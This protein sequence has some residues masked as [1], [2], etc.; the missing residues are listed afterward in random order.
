MDYWGEDEQVE[1]EQASQEL[2]LVRTL[3][4]QHFP[5]M[6]YWK[7]MVRTPADPIPEVDAG[8]QQ[9]VTGGMPPKRRPYPFAG[10]TV[11]ATPPEWKCINIIYHGSFA[12]MH[13]GHI[14]CIRDAMALLEEHHL[15]I[16]SVIVGCTTA[17]QVRKKLKGETPFTEPSKRAKLIK[18]VLQ[19]E[20]MTSVIVDEEGHSSSAALAWKHCSDETRYTNVYLSGSDV[21]SRPSY[22]SLMV[23]RGGKDKVA[24][25]WL[26]KKK[27]AGVCPQTSAIGSSSTSIRERFSRGEIPE[28]YQQNAR[29]YLGELLD[30][31]AAQ[32]HQ[33][34]Q[35]STGC[36]QDPTPKA[37]PMP[38][39]RRAAEPVELRT[40]EA[41]GSTDRPPLRRRITQVINVEADVVQDRPPL[42]RRRRQQ[43]VETHQHAAE[44]HVR[45]DHTLHR[46]DYIP[47]L[48]DASFT[49]PNQRVPTV[50][51]ED[52][53]TRLSRDGCMK[54]AHPLF[55]HLG[56]FHR[57]VVVPVCSLYRVM[58]VSTSRRSN[59]N[60]IRVE[61]TPATGRQ[62]PFTLFDSLEEFMDLRH[63]LGCIPATY[64]YIAMT[65]LD[66]VIKDKDKD[67]TRGIHVRELFESIP[68]Y[69]RSCYSAAE[70]VFAVVMY[71]AHHLLCVLR[72]VEDKELQT[73]SAE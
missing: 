24:N 64:H 49:A 46:D 44:D 40:D 54:L 32:G 41:R 52:L 23:H 30:H 7:H 63:A 2:L 42:Q 29:K 14:S 20:N 48:G 19:D 34:D 13:Q 61:Y 33:P 21:V 67:T 60:C 58:P 37:K 26:D 31:P 55:S 12:P 6:S 43:Q 51:V 5:S 73:V 70:T 10:T 62:T 57:H 17:K 4:E 28:V 35:P 9:V 22:C 16:R 1:K 25:A 72:P 47:P 8:Q 27:L 71:E 56:T 45:E 65:M 18:A 11:D 50:M 59:E 38:K 39:K 68:D 15:E 69:V 53:K 3:L 66:F 36:V